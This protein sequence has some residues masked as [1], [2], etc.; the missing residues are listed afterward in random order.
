MADL[1]EQKKRWEEDVMQPAVRR[2]PERREQFE[3]SSGI[4]LERVFLLH[5]PSEAVKEPP[6]EAPEEQAPPVA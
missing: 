5:P 1:S 3:T 6:H 2:S 4:P